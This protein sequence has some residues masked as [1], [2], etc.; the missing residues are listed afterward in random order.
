MF[1]VGDKVKYINEQTS[2]LFNKTGV[3]RIKMRCL[4]GIEFDTKIN[5]NNLGRI[6]ENNNGRYVSNHELE[7]LE[8]ESTCEY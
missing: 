8:M 3:V 1:Q 7:L 2:E 6:L 5:G 4:C